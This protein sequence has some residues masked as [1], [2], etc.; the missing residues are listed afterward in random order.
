MEKRVSN[1]EYTKS[2]IKEILS[3]K[4]TIEKV[5]K[6][7]IHKNKL[8]NCRIFLFDEEKSNFDSSFK[9]YEIGSFGVY[10]VGDYTKTWVIDSE[11]IADKT[12][13]KVGKTVNFDLNILT[14][15]NKIMQGRKINIDEKEFIKYL[16]YLK[17][18]Q[19]QNGMMTA[20]MERV[21]TPMELNIF[22]EMITSFVK[23]DNMSLVDES[24]VDFY[25]Y[26][27]DYL[28]VKQIYDSGLSQIGEANSQ[29][30][31]ICC[32][33]MKAFLLK[34]FGDN[35]TDEEK[36]EELIKYCLEILNCYLEKEIVLLSLYI[37]NDIR[38]NKTFKKLT[39][40][41]NV[42]KNILNVS[43]DIYHIRLIEQIMQI[44]YK[45][46]KEKDI[47][48]LPYFATADKG[49]I[50]A[51]KINPVKAVV[52]FENYSIVYHKLCIQDI[53]KNMKI[54]ENISSKVSIRAKK[55]DSVNFTKI[56]K[57]LEEEIK[58]NI[59]I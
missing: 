25:L 35:L 4:T 8:N 52:L 28:K 58:N 41:S 44:D 3:S 23:F 24:C 51:M 59:K 27:D 7:K 34:N 16:N 54:I 5:N 1:D 48:V 6:F 57:Q 36:I 18:C 9:N 47:I 20:I 14:Y 40:N 12:Y 56:R 26:P 21:K 43:W 55:I 19:F 33:V 29:F 11:H 15:L 13:L 49:L 38:T 53:C 42:M 22:V 39:N 50:D 46:K 31:I 32:C 45:Y 2:I 37:A 30:N 10:G 17:V